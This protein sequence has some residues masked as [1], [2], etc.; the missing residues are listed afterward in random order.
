MGEKAYS[1]KGAGMGLQRWGIGEEDWGSG[2]GEK[3]I[4]V[5]YGKTGVEEQADGCRDG[6]KGIRE[7]GWGH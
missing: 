4:H 6:R 3:G 7:Q 2:A 1:C 5:V